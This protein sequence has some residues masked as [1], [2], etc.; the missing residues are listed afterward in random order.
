MWPKIIVIVIDWFCYL[1][2]HQDQFASFSR[3]GN[4][5]LQYHHIKPC[6]SVQTAHWDETCCTM[7]KRSK[8]LNCTVVVLPICPNT[9][10]YE[11]HIHYWWFGILCCGS[12]VATFSVTFLQCHLM[13]GVWPLQS[14]LLLQA[15]DLMAEGEHGTAVSRHLVL[16]ISSDGSW[17]RVPHAGLYVTVTLHCTCPWVLYHPR[18]HGHYRRQRESKDNGQ[19][20]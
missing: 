7:Y 18:M 3:H 15:L 17:V 1:C 11:H 8:H 16:Y 13:S 9:I 6:Y 4:M 14:I 19:D 20:R 2:A 12:V 10:V 5:F